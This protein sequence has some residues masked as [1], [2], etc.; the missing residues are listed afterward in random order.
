MRTNTLSRFLGFSL[1]SIALAGTAAADEPKPG[2]APAEQGQRAQPVGAVVAQKMSGSATIQDIKKDDRT[3]TLKDDQG[4]TFDLKVPED[5]QRFDELKT[6][7]KINIAYYEA[8][9]LSL[10][11]SSGAAPSAGMTTMVERE[12]GPLPGGV[13]AKKVQASVTV[14]KVDKA[15]N[16]VVIKDSSGHLDTVHVNDPDGKAE[17]AMLKPGD[18]IQASYTQAVAISVER[19]DKEKKK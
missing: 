4:N 14:V 16:A 19:K 17:L 10:K 8:V 12:P 15:K 9:G 5:V 3:L 13:M 1:V 18:K 2:T 6:G 11:K 7:D